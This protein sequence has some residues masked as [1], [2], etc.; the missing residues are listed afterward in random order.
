[1]TQQLPKI[2]HK[3]LAV[4]MVT[5]VSLQSVYA[6]NFVSDSVITAK[7]KNK[8]AHAQSM[9]APNINIE[10]KDGIVKL[11]GVVASDTDACTVVQLA[12][13]TSGVRDV[14]T[15]DL[16]VKSSRT[17]ISDAFITAKV[18]GSYVQQK[19]FG[20]SPNIQPSNISVETNNGVVFLS[21]EVQSKQVAHKAISLAR[22]IKGVKKVNYRLNV[23]K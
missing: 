19:L 18:K 23:Q 3:I 4:T 20:D 9:Q 17:P 5:F 12:Q 6:S 7:V 2:L 11:N 14:N 22:S 16:Y 1:M 10:T 8:V 21:G 15:K 13:S